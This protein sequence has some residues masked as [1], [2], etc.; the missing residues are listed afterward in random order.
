MSV[1]SIRFARTALRALPTAPRIPLLRR[2]YAEA[3][4]DKIKLS[5]ALPHQSVYKSTDVVQVNIPAESGEM[6]ILANHVPSIEQLKPG[7]VEIIEESG[8]S[9]QYFLSGGFAIV[10]P[11]SQLSI[12]A[13]EGFPLEDFSADAVKSQISEAQRV[14]SGGGSEQDIAEAK[15]ELEPVNL[16]LALVLSTSLEFSLFNFSRC[17]GNACRFL[18]DMSYQAL[19]VEEISS[20]TTHIRPA[21]LPNHSIIAGTVSSL[22]QSWNNLNRP[23]ISRPC[24]P[25]LQNPPA[26]IRERC[27]PFA[28][29]S[30]TDP[31]AD[32]PGREGSNS[33]DPKQESPIS[34]F[35][36]FESQ[37]STFSKRKS[38]IST[39][40]RRG[41]LAA[42]SPKRVPTVTSPPDKDSPC[43][44]AGERWQGKSWVKREFADKKNGVWT[45]PAADTEDLLISPAGTI[46]AH[47]GENTA[48]EPMAADVWSPLVEEDVR[49][50][51]RK[52]T[53]QHPTEQRRCLP[54]SWY[55]S[56]QHDEDDSPSAST[57]N[58]HLEKLKAIGR[59]H[60]LDFEPAEE[61][62]DYPA[63]HEQLQHKIRMRNHRRCHRCGE[64]YDFYNI[65]LRCG[66]KCCRECPRS[67]SERLTEE[68]WATIDSRSGAQDGGKSSSLLPMTHIASSY[69]GSASH[70][71]GD[72]A[73]D[74]SAY[75]EALIEDID[76]AIT[77]TS[78]AYEGSQRESSQGE[79]SDDAITTSEVDQKLTTPPGGF[80]DSPNDSYGAYSRR[81][82]D[83][84][85]QASGYEDLIIIPGENLISLDDRSITKELGRGSRSSIVVE[86]TTDFAIIPNRSHGDTT[87][88]F[89]AIGTS[90]VV[91]VAPSIQPTPADATMIAQQQTPIV[92]APP[93]RHLAAATAAEVL[94]RGVA[95]MARHR[96]T[97]IV[98][99]RRLS[100]NSAADNNAIAAENSVLV[101]P[102]KPLVT[103][104]LATPSQPLSAGSSA[105]SITPTHSLRKP[106]SGD[107]VAASAADVPQPRFWRVQRPTQD[108]I[109]NYP[110]RQSKSLPVTPGDTAR[111]DPRQVSGAATTVGSPP[112]E[113]IQQGSVA[114]R[115]RAWEQNAAAVVGVPP[116][117]ILPL[118]V[119]QDRG[120]RDQQQE[121]RRGSGDSS[122]S[123]RAAKRQKLGDGDL[124]TG[125]SPS[126]SQDRQG[127]SLESGSSGSSGS[128][129]RIRVVVEVPGDGGDGDSVNEGEQDEARGGKKGRRW[130][131]EVG[132]DVDV[133]F[134]FGVL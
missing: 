44:T 123:G 32:S 55:R 116:L 7:L 97:G 122:V 71:G 41:S 131:V 1:N 75:I 56:P 43:A 12:N 67:P 35:P 20:I 86:L 109:L 16:T 66:H 18:V 11:G 34:T 15:I 119:G 94:S 93:S 100:S 81:E 112:R 121:G 14:V 23:N 64:I 82:R 61:K 58:A 85:A 88:R 106:K 104:I 63:Q 78:G 54:E 124:G 17:T 31:V 19:T 127:Q 74:E 57:S 65:C 68:R 39:F 53:T 70:D 76:N 102:A 117:P 132:V 24:S 73:G 51:L 30:D 72:D 26:T 134:E 6:G 36:R 115:A 83:A 49:T 38:T 120:K 105:R 99:R 77:T 87:T 52:L 103:P 126:L 114:A 113:T 42:A 28:A 62:P 21:N 5:L 47:E 133:D 111:P 125:S 118:S 40:S 13:V 60:G 79:D 4:P 84:Q 108:T 8:G 27:A 92:I 25:S 2:S 45:R 10:Q 33:P 128:S 59:K 107:D 3:I 80:P 95:I 129:N 48:G 46:S 101:A 130:V 50:G 110:Q 9:K 22:I 96:R 69:A 89:P 29:R 37:V 98:A 90:H 91:T